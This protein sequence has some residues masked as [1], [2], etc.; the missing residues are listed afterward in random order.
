MKAIILTEALGTGAG[1]YTKGFRTVIGDGK[2]VKNFTK[3][4]QAEL[5]EEVVNFIKSLPR[6]NRLK[7]LDKDTV[8]FATQ[9][10]PGIFD[11]D[12]SMIEPA[13]RVLFIDIPD[14]VGSAF[15]MTCSSKPLVL[16]DGTFIEE[17]LTVDGIKKAI[18]DIMLARKQ[19]S[20]RQ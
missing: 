19:E 9:R 11:E 18:S 12:G 17:P 14:G 5:G 13:Q 16:E 8:Y 4:E 1:N 20:S 2:V 15:G 10:V 3:T 7:P 6:G